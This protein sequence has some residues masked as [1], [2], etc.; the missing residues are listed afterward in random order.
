MYC[1]RLCIG[2]TVVKLSIVTSRVGGKINRLSVNNTTEKFAQLTE[3]EADGQG[4]SKHTFC[5]MDCAEEKNRDLSPKS[6]KETVG[7]SPR[8]KEIWF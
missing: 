6:V 7:D 8:G 5:R 1:A 2:F 4:R 3:V